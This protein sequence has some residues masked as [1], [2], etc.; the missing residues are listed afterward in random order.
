MGFV[1]RAKTRPRETHRPSGEP[2]VNPDGK[3]C[4]SAGETTGYAARDAAGRSD[5]DYRCSNC[6]KIGGAVAFE[7]RIRLFCFPGLMSP[8]SARLSIPIG[9][10]AGVGIA[11]ERYTRQWI[12]A[13]SAVQRFPR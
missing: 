10:G 6:Y 2:G 5:G 1:G 3:D 7:I 8:F 4:G 13:A 11:C 12:P 9:V